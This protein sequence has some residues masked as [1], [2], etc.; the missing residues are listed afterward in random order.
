MGIMEDALSVSS[1]YGWD[2]KE[3]AFESSEL[4]AALFALRH[5]GIGVDLM[6]DLNESGSL[7]SMV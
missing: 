7:V 5:A 6:I 3:S 1:Y 2:G 4:L